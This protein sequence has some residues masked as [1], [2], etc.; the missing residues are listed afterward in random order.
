MGGS[1]PGVRQSI[2]LLKNT[3]SVRVEPALELDDGDQAK[4]TASYKPQ[5]GLDVALERVDRDADGGCRL[6]SSER[7]SERFGTHRRAP[8]RSVTLSPTAPLKGGRRLG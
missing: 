1:A 7:Q 8:L 2:R 5:L 4:A 6:R 3:S